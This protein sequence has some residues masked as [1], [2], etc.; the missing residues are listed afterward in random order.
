MRPSVLSSLLITFSLGLFALGVLSVINVVGLTPQNDWLDILNLPSL[1][2]IFGGISVHALISFPASDLFNAMGNLLHLASHKDNGKAILVKKGQLFLE[3]Q[4]LLKG[5]KTV[6]AEKLSEDLEGRFE[7]YL[8]SLMATN[9]DIGEVRDLGTAWIN[10]AYEASLRESHVMGTLGNASPA[11]GMLGTLMGLIYM[12]QNFQAAEY[13][14]VGLSLALM[15]TLYGL[16][17]AQFVWY[18]LSNK[19]RLKADITADN[20]QRSLQA[21]L[22]LMEDKP[23]L[24]ISDFFTAN[25][26]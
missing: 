26:K 12:L 18:P 25:I 20:E 9:Y 2:I 19:I 6:V 7:G 13:L 5:N 16:A 11:Y 4:H 15:T 22:M 14:G 24:Y 17:L 10:A 3:W 8:F 23:G 1:L 21:F